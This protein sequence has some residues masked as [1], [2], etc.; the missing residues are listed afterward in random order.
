M[1]VAPEVAVLLDRLRNH[2]MT[3]YQHSCNVGNL[4][5]ALAEGLGLQQEEVNIITVGG[6]LHD[7]GKARVRAAILHKAARLT[8]GEWEVMRR[9][10]EFGVQILSGNEKFEVLEPLVAYHHERWD[11]Q[12]YYGLGGSDIPLGARII[13]LA[14][15]FDA[16]TSC[17]AYQ[18]SKN[19]LDGIQELAAGAGK[20]FDPR[21]VQLFFDIMPAILKRNSRRAS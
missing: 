4:A 7:I 13:A 1:S 20:Q 16:M 12:G 15:A 17:R 5:C 6:L 11:G 18:Y 3:T 8:A 14:D 21:L 10:P 9:H 19:L 2:S